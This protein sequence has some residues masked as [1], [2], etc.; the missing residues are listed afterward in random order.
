MA[1]KNLMFIIFIEA[2]QNDK[3]INEDIIKPV[4]FCGLISLVSTNL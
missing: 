3:N 2:K 1:S 4:N